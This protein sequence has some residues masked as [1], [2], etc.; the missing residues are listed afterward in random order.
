MTRKRRAAAA[1]AGVKFT[2]VFMR[3]DGSQLAELARWIEAGKLRP[4]IHQSF[5]LAQYKDAFA[6]LVDHP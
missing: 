4:I 3:P 5:P 1:K 6:E 2:Y